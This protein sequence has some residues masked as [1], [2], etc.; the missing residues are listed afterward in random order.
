MYLK[1]IGIV[2]R[3]ESSDGNLIGQRLIIVIVSGGGRDRLRSRTGSQCCQLRRRR[4][5]MA[6]CL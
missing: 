3:Q 1:R 2:W 5:E 4:I 6:L